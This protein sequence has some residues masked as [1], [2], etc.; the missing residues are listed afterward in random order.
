MDAHVV[1]RNS[2]NVYNDVLGTGG[3]V[4]KRDFAKVSEACRFMVKADVEGNLLDQALFGRSDVELPDLPSTGTWFAGANKAFNSGFA[5]SRE[6]Q[7]SPWSYLLA[8][9]GA[10]LLQ[11][12]TGKAARS[13][14]AGIRDLSVY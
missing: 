8:L 13:E 10:L 5:V 3:N 4:G 9:E 6:G 12:G 11:G 2:R 1:A 7:L 14:G